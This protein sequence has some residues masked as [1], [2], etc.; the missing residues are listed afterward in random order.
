MA[1]IDLRE[2]SGPAA[3]ESKGEL[4]DENREL[5]PAE[6]KI[7][8]SIED[9]IKFERRVFRDA[10]RFLAIP[11][12]RGNATK[13]SVGGRD[14]RYGACVARWKHWSLKVAKWK[15]AGSCDMAHARAEIEWVYQRQMGEFLDK[16]EAGETAVP[17][18]G[19]AEQR[20]AG[21]DR[22]YFLDTWENGLKICRL[23][24]G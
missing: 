14:T 15:T 12:G 4:T 22:L 9:Y 5:S 16:I 19:E 20:P 18:I 10:G 7:P 6:K 3:W 13:T 8:F 2:L 11:I 23:N 21:M 24:A 17:G 1:D